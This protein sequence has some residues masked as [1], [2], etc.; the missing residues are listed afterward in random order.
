MVIDVHAHLG[1]DRVFDEI[2][3]EDELIASM[4]KNH[5]D[6][7]IVQNMTGTIDMESIRADN[8]RIFRFSLKYGWHCDASIRGEIS[9]SDCLTIIQSRI[10]FWTTNSKKL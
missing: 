3:T 10:K 2:R 9:M 8:D 5:V 6:A 7:T 1:L 4:A